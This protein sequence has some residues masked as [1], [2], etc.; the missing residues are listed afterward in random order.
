MHARA[1]L[2]LIL[3]GLFGHSPPARADELRLQLDPAQ[4]EITFELGAILHTVSGTAELIEGLVIF[5][6][7]GGPASGRIVV[8]AGSADTANKGRDKDMH[9]KVLE[10]ERYPE[11][12]FRP[13]TLR[14]EVALDGRSRVEID[15]TFSVHG[16]EHPLTVQAQIDVIGDELEVTLEFEVPYVAWGMKNPSKLL[17]RVSKVVRVRIHG[18]G[19]L[20]PAR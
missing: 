14:G 11:I 2:V 16:G 13:H 12:E 10:S 6:T 4:T 18:F 1:L 7:E 20:G 19:R 17:L 15:G 9:A 3:I 5:D 8:A